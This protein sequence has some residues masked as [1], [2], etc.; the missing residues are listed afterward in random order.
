MSSTLHNV[1]VLLTPDQVASALQTLSSLPDIQVNTITLGTD[2]SIDIPDTP[3]WLKIVSAGSLAA[4]CVEEGLPQEV[5]EQ[6]CY[7]FLQGASVLHL[8]GSVTE[9]ELDH[10]C[11]ALDGIRDSRKQLQYFYDRANAPLILDIARSGVP[12]E[13][14]SGHGS[15]IDSAIFSPDGQ[16]ILT[17]SEDE[18]AKVW[19][20]A[21]GKVLFTLHGSNGRLTGTSYSPGGNVILAIDGHE[22]V[23]V[24]DAR[25]GQEYFSFR[26]DK[27]AFGPDGSSIAAIDDK[28][29]KVVDP[30]TEEEFIRVPGLAFTYS[31]DG[32]SILTNDDGDTHTIWDIQT[33]KPLLIL[34][35]KPLPYGFKKI[36]FSHDG[37]SVLTAVGGADTSSVSI[38]DIKTGQE[39]LR[40]AGFNPMYSPDGKIMVTFSRQDNRQ[41]ATIWDVWSRQEIWQFSEVSS[42]IFSPDGET[43]ATVSERSTRTNVNVQVWNTRTMKELFSVS[44]EGPNSED[45][46]YN[47]DIRYSPD[48]LYLLITNQS[49]PNWYNTNAGPTVIDGSTEVW[50]VGS[51]KHLFTLTGIRPEYSPTTKQVVTVL[52]DGRAAIWDASEGHLIRLLGQVRV[53]LRVKNW[54]LGGG[55]RFRPGELSETQVVERFADVQYPQQVR[56]R[57]QFVINVGLIRHLPDEEIEDAQPA[58]VKVTIDAEG[59]NTGANLVEVTL[60]S[61]GFSLEVNRGQLEVYAD[62][63][64]PPL[65]FQLEPKPGMT[66]LYPVHVVF[67]QG[68]E[69]L[70][71]VVVV[72]EVMT[73]TV[74]LVSRYGN[75][76]MTL[77]QPPEEKWGK[78]APPDVVLYITRQTFQGRDRLT[79][80]YEWVQQGWPKLDGGELELGSSVE[81]WAASHFTA[82]SKFARPRMPGQVLGIDSDQRELEKIG[83]NLYYELF[84]PQLKV[85]YKQFAPSARSLLIY[86]NE[87]WIP[88]EVIKPWGDGLDEQFSDFLCAKFQLSRWYTNN[89][90]RRIRSSIDLQ[91]LRA[92]IPPSNLPYVGEEAAYFKRLQANW[93]PLSVEILTSYRGRDVLSLMEMGTINLFHFATHGA[94]QPGTL[95]V[96][97]ISLGQGS[98]LVGDLVGT[99]LEEGLASSTPLI[100]MNACH[101]GRL[102]LELSKL[103]GWAD[104][105][106]NFGCSGFIGA[107][108]EVHDRLAS[109]F[110]I[111]FYDSL[112]SH[113]TVA[114]A[115]QK[116][117]LAMR[118]FDPT[119]STWLAYSLYAHPNLRVYTQDPHV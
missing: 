12:P 41:I 90:G 23:Q 34:P 17:T 33:G 116:A 107:N 83:E 94:L 115:V 92:V 1:L 26:G 36:A 30:R 117:R 3:S 100:F 109:L 16:T 88:W 103:E 46:I 58:K 55:G 65:P 87:P 98:I 111:N 119:N 75:K 118:T 32:K 44:I 114:Q 110:A 57:Q 14:V 80:R 81:D 84:T 8:K 10:L 9:S 35:T 67:Y 89:N 66:G 19:E 48:G 108:W 91:T 74:M 76:H 6:F 96:A 5:T 105:F 20:V 52:D 69:C 28:T 29:V 102:S 49:G 61:P 2:D 82:L 31:S 22:Q 101:S 38:W 27:A 97:A 24:W 18:T 64:T 13:P 106:V 21:T 54:G 104:R 60:Y 70:G 7:S 73:D 99:R 50:E 37:K 25:T 68:Y 79:Y 40:I 56:S 51:G 78:V 42:V 93:P 86:S 15:T 39:Y 63:D 72:I 62:K 113:N 95:P 59:H 47:S 45:V 77:R 43:I 71:E 4:L 112:R 11:I 85:F 53:R